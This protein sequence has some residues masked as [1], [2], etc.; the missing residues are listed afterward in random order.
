MKK[1]LLF[2]C[3]CLCL[4]FFVATAASADSL[5][6][7]MFDVDGKKLLIPKLSSLSSE[8]TIDAS[9]IKF[10]LKN[11][12]NDKRFVEGK[13]FE[14][15][16]SRGGRSGVVRWAIFTKWTEEKIEIFYSGR[17]P[18]SGTEPFLDCVPNDGKYEYSKD[19]Y[20]CVIRGRTSGNTFKIIFQDKK[21]DI[22]AS[23]GF[24]AESKV[25]GEF[26]LPVTQTTQD[27]A[28]VRVQP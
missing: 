19:E 15:Q 20:R 10:D 27:R 9:S 11:I 21:I 28:P 24:N 8:D 23:D 2:I 26:V 4:S 17:L 5:A 12:P 25:S 13:I 14:F 22:K 7:A 3:I 16:F 1:K 18:I 6:S